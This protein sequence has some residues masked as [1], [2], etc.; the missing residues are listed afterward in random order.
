MPLLQRAGRLDQ[1][2][3]DAVAAARLPGFEY[4]LPRLSK[5]ADHSLLWFGVAGGL[6]LTRQPRL[7]RAALRGAFA[8]GLASPLANLAGKQMFRRR[9]PLIEL[10]GLPTS[11]GRG[12]I[13]PASRVRWRLPTS[14]SFPSGHSAAA[15]AF[16]GALAMEAPKSVVLP[17]A[18]A[19]AGVAFSRIYTGAHY[20]GDVM[21]GLALGAVAA[22]ATRLIW[23]TRPAPGGAVWSM[24]A[25][26]VQGA[27]PEGDGVVVVINNDAGGGDVSKLLRSELPNAEILEGGEDLG[28]TLSDAADRATVLGVCGGDGTINAG[29]EIAVERDLPLL[30]IPGG[31]LNHF[32]RAIGLETAKDA[33]AAYKSGALVRVDV[34][35]ADERLFLN[36]ASFGAYTE[37][38]DLRERLQNRLGKWPALAV[39]AVR[40]LRHTEP[41]EVYVEGRLMRVWFAFLGNCHY[42]SYG[43][44]PTWREHLADGLLDIRLIGAK[45]H[46]GKSRAVA[47]LLIGH[48]HLM[49]DYKSWRATSLTVRGAEGS[50]RLA[51]DGELRTAEGTVKI[52]KRRAG[53][54][55]FGPTRVAEPHHR[56]LPEPRTEGD[57]PDD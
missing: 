2:A 57:R 31:T 56:P 53:L 20:P 29:A 22:G 25:E 19:A 38:V 33:I 9:R 44:A 40:V 27:S 55:V 28:K 13:L 5:A 3:F 43:V 10:A 30:V 41:T 51:C 23:P 45:R 6:A 49:P 48:L 52:T 39:A 36:T 4:V 24:P 1:R 8:I 15:A 47:A 11:V 12:T 16:T 21:A 34:A 42:G 46:I 7:R 37:L 26:A 54:A 50:M 18:T 32:A 14:S 35:C 17:V